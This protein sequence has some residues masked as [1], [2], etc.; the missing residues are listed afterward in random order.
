MRGALGVLAIILPLMSTVSICGPAY[1][2]PL[3]I[4]VSESQAV[5]HWTRDGTKIVFAQ[6]PRGI[7]VVEADGSRM[8]SIPRN[9][10]TWKP[11]GSSDD[12]IGNFSPAISP[13]GSRVAYAMVDGE[14][15][16]IVVSNIDGSNL[17]KLTKNSAV[18]A[19]PAWSP[20]GKQIAFISYRDGDDFQ[21]RLFVMNSDGSKQRSLAPAVWTTDHAPVWSPDG[22]RIAFVV[23]Q[24]DVVPREDSSRRT[25]TVPRH[26]LYTVKPD[27]SEPRILGD[28]GSVAAWSPDGSR[29]AFIRREGESSSLV[30]MDP[31]GNE[32]QQLFDL[33]RNRSQPYGSLSWSPDGSEIL[34]PS[35]GR[36][37]VRADGS[38]I[39]FL[40]RQPNNIDLRLRGIT[41]W[42]PDG[43]RIALRDSLEFNDNVLVTVAPDGSDARVLVKA[44]PTELVA[45]NDNGE[46]TSEKIKACSDG[47][48]ISRP[49]WK[50]GLVQDCE[51]LLQI[52]DA[53]AGEGALNWSPQVEFEK[54]DGMV[55]KGFSPRV[56]ELSLGGGAAGKLK[57]VIPPE[58][59]NLNAL[60]KLD[61]SYNDLRGNI[62][63]AMGNLS[64]LKELDLYNNQLN[65]PIPPELGNLSNLEKLVLSGN[66]LTGP[67]P[68][69]IGNLTRLKSLRIRGNRLSGPI[70]LELG[71]LTALESFDIANADLTGCMP[72]ELRSILD[73][74]GTTEIDGY[75]WC[76]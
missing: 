27:G 16:N 49:G 2:S 70:P 7:F 50:G 30:T 28:T 38:S 1:D 34:L 10:P 18:D 56:V 76:R 75:E 64:N 69:E 35:T 39:R 13:D 58:L 48:L 74:E 24:R 68:S 33:K 42:S 6:P 31:H 66:Y 53:L 29:I 9:A 59:A 52:R 47:S 36:P 41:A 62:P 54:W 61:L 43:S 73:E 65:G 4:S 46:N 15:S 23:F 51:T 20:D 11:G 71:N 57:G 40:D 25:R 17:R 22:S 21:P 44:G 8:W 12:F 67:I 26:I 5:P 32:Q 14:S 45:A 72:T 63:P 19:Y 60:S 37:I 55:I 3:V